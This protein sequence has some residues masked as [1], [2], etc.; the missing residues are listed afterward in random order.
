M[1][2]KSNEDIRAVNIGALTHSTR[3]ILLAR[4]AYALTVCARSTYEPGTEKV[5][6][7]S[8]L[9][10]Y[11]ELM[12]RVTSCIL[13]HVQGDERFPLEAILQMMREFGAKF[14]RVDEINQALEMALDKPLPNEH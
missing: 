3:T 5:R 14:D 1:V 11:N 8:V 12:H 6:E 7:P 13:S 4:I 9:R 10:G 2:A